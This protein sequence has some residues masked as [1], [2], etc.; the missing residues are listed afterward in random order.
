MDKYWVGAEY[1]VSGDGHR[2]VLESLKNYMIKLE[3]IQSP[4]AGAGGMFEGLVRQEAAKRTPQVNV[5]LDRVQSFLIGTATA[6]SLIDYIPI[7]N[8]ALDSYRSDLTRTRSDT[9]D[10]HTKSMIDSIDEAKQAI[11]KFE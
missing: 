8:S 7:I 6:Q 2:I 11:N 4:R 9:N 3:D 1:M 5:V 10:A